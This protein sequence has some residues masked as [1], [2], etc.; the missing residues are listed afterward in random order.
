MD[1]EENELKVELKGETEVVVTRYFAAPRELV[2]DC[3]TKP[4]NEA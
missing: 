1:I 3:H 4:V 2:F